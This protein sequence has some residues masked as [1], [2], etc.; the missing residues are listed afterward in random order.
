M[1]EL[2]ILKALKAEEFE[3][4]IATYVLPKLGFT[5]RSVTGSPGDVGCD[6]IAVDEI[7]KKK[8]CIQIKKYSDK[9]V[10][11]SDVRKVKVGMDYYGCER[12]LIITTSELSGP[13]VSEAEKFHIDYIDG[14]RLVDIIRKYNIPIPM[15]APDKL[16][17]SIEVKRKDEKKPDVKKIKDDGVYV[18]LTVAEAVKKGK[19]AL[20]K[21]SQVSL[22]D[23]KAHLKR[24]YFYK[25]KVSYKLKGR[26][27]Q[28]LVIGI[29]G[30]GELYEEVP[31]LSKTLECDVEYETDREF[32]YSAREKVSR[33]AE[34]QAPNDASEVQVSMEE[35]K[36]A[37]VVSYY[38][39]RFK[40]GLTRATVIIDRKGKVKNVEIEP[41]TES[42]LLKAYKGN[43][44]RV[45]NGWKIVREDEKFIETLTL[46]EAG[47]V[48]KKERKIKGEYAKK[49][50]KTADKGE[51]VSVKDNIVYSDHGSYLNE[52]VVNEAEQVNC[53][54]IGIGS[55]KALEIAKRDFINT[56]LA[57]PSASHLEFNNGWVVKLAGV[58]GNAEYFIQLNGMFNSRKEINEN[59]AKIFL[60]RY[61]NVQVR[62]EGD[63]IIGEGEDN[64]HIYHYEWRVDG[65]IL[66]NIRRIKP[67]YA[68][69]LTQSF[70]RIAGGSI[71]YSIKDD[72]VKVD[73]LLNLMH[74]LAKVDNEGRIVDY[75]IVPDMSAYNGVKKG[76]NKKRR[77]LIVRVDE[78]D[79]ESVLAIDSRG[80]IGK[81]EIPK[82]LS[83]RKIG[84]FMKEAVSSE[85]SIDTT[86]PLDLI[87]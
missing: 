1:D 10:T 12:G 27:S 25:V 33:Y 24:L 26:R 82:K 40:V 39:L 80:V 87:S 86:D 20:S 35:Y 75:V 69:L 17:N 84:F 59:Y 66:E 29:D 5:I 42:T 65:Q 58:T 54:Q 19:E 50:V 70:Y 6:V 85:Y 8:W 30:D 45:N 43:V 2:T 31:T 46:N 60:S 55:S 68:V 3:N 72:G 41:L 37:W 38:I 49:L 7:F 36:L 74:Y 34:D 63:K 21:Y 47:E 18:T 56:M 61:N 57:M 51:I 11:A 83:W 44:L 9:K 14:I 67:E 4:Y 71:R 76:Y 13:A 32:Y 16:D 15:V 48:I 73:I 22:E 78:G 81:E 28:Q 52:C 64:T 79:K 62:R 23:V 53:R 77:C